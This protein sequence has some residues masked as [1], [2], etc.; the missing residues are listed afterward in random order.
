[1]LIFSALC[2][3]RARA[4]CERRPTRWVPSQ[5]C[6]APSYM[7][8]KKT[9]LLCSLLLTA[10]SPPDSDTVP[11]ALPPCTSYDSLIFPFRALL[12]EPTSL[13][14]PGMVWQ[15]EG[16]SHREQNRSYLDGGGAALLV[17]A[18]TQQAVGLHVIPWHRH[19][20]HNMQAVAATQ[21]N[22]HQQ[23]DKVKLCGRTLG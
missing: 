18:F 13:A 12:Q 4:A 5:R 23:Q 22:Q 7:L 1:M 9:G 21:R 20:L 11:L 3:Y 19:R 8:S 6:L 16:T 15:G 14:V 17:L 10:R 2:Q